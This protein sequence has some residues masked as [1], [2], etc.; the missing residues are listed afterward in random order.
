MKR[1][2]TLKLTKAELAD[3]MTKQI[4]TIQS[5][6]SEK[7]ELMAKISDLEAELLIMR[8]EGKGASL[9]TKKLVAELN[10]DLKHLKKKLP[11]YRIDWK[12]LTIRQYSR[13]CN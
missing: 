5:N 6:K 13:R 2:L 7:D 1:N 10:E 3:A 8:E 12:I 9:E 11:N 4:E